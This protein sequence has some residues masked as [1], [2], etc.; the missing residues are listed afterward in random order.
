M[1]PQCGFKD[2]VFKIN[3][4]LQLHFTKH[5]T[6]LTVPITHAARRHGAVTCELYNKHTLWKTA[7]EEQLQIHFN[8]HGPPDTTQQSW[9]LLQIAILHQQTA[10]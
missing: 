9:S 6:N 4:T 1:I 10:I 3:D 8:K 7:H 2:A 5:S